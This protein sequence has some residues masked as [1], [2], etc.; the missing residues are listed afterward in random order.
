MKIHVPLLNSCAT[1]CA[2]L[3]EIAIQDNDYYGQQTLVIL[4]NTRDLIQDMRVYDRAVRCSPA[5][6][7]FIIK[8]L[9]NK[10]FFTS[11]L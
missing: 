1:S 6:P 5:P 2:T 9:I 4:Y 10:G 7:I 11:T 3:H 8:P